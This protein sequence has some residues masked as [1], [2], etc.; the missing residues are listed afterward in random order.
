MTKF[1]L[2]HILF[3]E[4]GGIGYGGMWGDYCHTS[5]I[6]QNIVSGKNISLGERKC[7]IIF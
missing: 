5:T 1:Y 3:K 7:I 6:K 2:K 4:F